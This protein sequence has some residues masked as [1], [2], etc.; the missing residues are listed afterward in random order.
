MA[1]KRHGRLPPEYIRVR[2]LD[3]GPQVMHGTPLSL[4]YSSQVR[5]FSVIKRPVRH[6]V[7]QSQTAHPDTGAR[8]GDTYPITSAL[9][10]LP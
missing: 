10:A 7:A 6:G 9:L 5:N 8:Q 1:A 2:E 4:G 3:C